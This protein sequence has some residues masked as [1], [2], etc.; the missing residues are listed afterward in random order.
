MGHDQFRLKV[1]R[2]IDLRPYPTQ[3]QHQFFSSWACGCGTGSHFVLDKIVIVIYI[4][5][6]VGKIFGRRLRPLLR[7]KNPLF[8]RCCRAVFPAVM[9][10]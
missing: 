4:I 3:L 5:G 6:V 7:P 10:L 8:R 2:A 9:S 1:I